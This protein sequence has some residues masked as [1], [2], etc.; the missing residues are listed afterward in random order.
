MSEFHNLVNEISN[1]Y[2]ILERLQE[3]YDSLL[4]KYITKRQA[5]AATKDYNKRK[6]ETEKNKNKNKNNPPPQPKPKQN[7]E[8]PKQ[9]EEKTKQEKKVVDD[10]KPPKN[11]T[12]PKPAQ[13]NNNTYGNTTFTARTAKIPD[14][15][16]DKYKYFHPNSNNDLCD[17]TIQR[18]KP[19]KTISKILKRIYRRLLLKLHPDRSPI[20]DSE[21]IC[22]KL[23][24]LYKQSDYS[25]MFHMFKIIDCK[26]RLSKNDKKI[27]VFFLNQ[28]LKRI[29]L[30][31]KILNENINNFK[32]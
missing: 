10:N 5:D 24:K 9:N 7:E 28:E 12:I 19:D 4:E 23:V 17:R 16:W 1:K 29:I 15:K 32:R 22:K 31:L 20:K 25:Y 26:I 14:N 18:L 30:T 8:K 27:L 2:L 3:E 11:T 21:S 13:T 6:K